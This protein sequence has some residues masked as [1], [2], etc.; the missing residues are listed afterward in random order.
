MRE[1]GNETRSTPDLII[2]DANM[3][4]MN[5]YEATK[6]IREEQVVHVPIICLSAQESAEHR[7]QCL[8]AGMDKVCMNCSHECL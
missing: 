7:E 6:M 2:M 5:G 1:K 4:V 8:E 3:P